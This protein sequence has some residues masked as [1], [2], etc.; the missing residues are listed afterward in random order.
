MQPCTSRCQT[1]AIYTTIYISHLLHATSNFPS[2][3]RS[4]CEITHHRHHRHHHRQGP[5]KRIYSAYIF[6]DGSEVGEVAEGV[7]NSNI[8]IISTVSQARTT[9]HWRAS[10]TSSPYSSSFIVSS[11]IPP[12][13]HWHVDACGMYLRRV[14]DFTEISGSAHTGTR[15]LRQTSPCAPSNSWDLAMAFY[16][17]VLA[18]T[19]LTTSQR[20]LKTMMVYTKCQALRIQYDLV[21]KDLDPSR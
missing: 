11:S 9:K 13:H 16:T 6:Y 21:A 14:E 19:L 8:S 1:Q 20:L 12:H 2:N 18:Q 4:S 7:N 10:S 15:Q 5:Q 3:K 17:K